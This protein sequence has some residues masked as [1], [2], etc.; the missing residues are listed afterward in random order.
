[1]RLR[2]TKTSGLRRIHL[3][4]QGRRLGNKSV[5]GTGNREPKSERRI[6]NGSNPSTK[7]LDAFRFKL[8]THRQG[9]ERL[10]RDFLA[11]VS[12]LVQFML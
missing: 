11:S 5:K 10:S 9:Y 2:R 1:M 12:A 3:F 7:R 6:V 8:S 4:L